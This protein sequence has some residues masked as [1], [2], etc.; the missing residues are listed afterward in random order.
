MTTDLRKDTSQFNEEIRNQAQLIFESVRLMKARTIACYMDYVAQ[1]GGGENF[2]E[3]TEPQMNMLM[4]VRDHGPLTVKDL[5]NRLRV[6]APSASSMVDRCVEMGALSREPDP[7]D[8]RRVVIRITDKALSEISD[9]EAHI[10]QSIGELLEK[11][12]PEYAALWSD[13]HQRV[14]NI[15]MQEFECTTPAGQGSENK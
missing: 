11:V 14:S 15:I 6:S 7:D 12:G 9:I 10:L 2:L 13:V 1:R 8:R 4:V 5:A 3:I